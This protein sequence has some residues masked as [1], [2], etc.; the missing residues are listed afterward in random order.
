MRQALQELEGPQRM[1]PLF[2]GEYLEGAWTSQ[3]TLFFPKSKPVPEEGV[4]EE[5]EQQQPHTS[6]LQTNGLERTDSCFLHQNPSRVSVV[7]VQ[8]QLALSI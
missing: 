6:L 2:K 7:P 8:K 5:E 3:P 1:M 4:N